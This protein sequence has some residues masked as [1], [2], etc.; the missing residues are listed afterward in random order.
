MN[1]ETAALVF[2]NGLS[3][4]ISVGLIFVMLIQPRRTRLNWLFSVFLASMSLWAVSA[5]V[6]KVP[7]LSL[8][9]ETDNFYF[10]FIGM[11]T[12]PIALYLFV[13]VFSRRMGRAALALTA[14]AAVVVVATVVL[15]WQGQVVDYREANMPNAGFDLK[16]AGYVALAHVIY[17]AALAYVHLFMSE[18]PQARLLRLP[19]LLLL[20]GYMA[21]LSQTLRQVP[22][23][24]ALTTLAAMLIGY[25]VLRWQLFNPLSEMNAQ[26]RIANNDLRLVIRDLAAE[27]EHTEQLNEELRAASR[28]KSEFLANMSHELRTPLNSIVGYSELL[29][30]GLYGDLTTKQLDRVE[31][32]FRNGH[33]LLALINDILDLSKIEG[34]RMDLNL[35]TIQ[36]SAMID[37]LIATVEPLANDKPLKLYADVETPLYEVMADELRLR[38]VITNLLSNA[39]KFTPSGHVRIT[40]RNVTVSNGKSTELPLPARGWL[41]DRDWVI[42]G[43]EDTG[44]GVPHDEQ[45]AIFEEFRQADGTVTREYEGAGLGLAIAKRLVE[46]HSGRIWVTSAPGEGSTFYVALPAFDARER[47]LDNAQVAR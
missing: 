35:R 2:A 31:K 45:S 37:A 43:V 14:W 4:S 41:E 29:L 46:L 17:Y 8:L 3:L 23:D 36:L 32:I 6:R 13:I 38:Q 9:S 39:I 47:M 33:N 7:E 20:F 42:L 15:L 24:I 30:K 16:L 28:Y 11:V 12:T 19:A 18:L 34:G 25:A 10:Q 27:K 44:I 1:L 5:I 22:L 26:L 40:A 21:N